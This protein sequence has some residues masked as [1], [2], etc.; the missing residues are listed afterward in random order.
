MLLVQIYEFIPNH[1]NNLGIFL[2]NEVLNTRMY[3]ELAHIITNMQRLYLLCTFFER[4]YVMPYLVVCCFSQIFSQDFTQ[5]RYK[6]LLR[7]A[8][9]LAQFN[10][11]I[12][13]FQLITR[14]NG[15]LFN[16]V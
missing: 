12:I 1:P 9:I 5:Q 10:I 11:Y 13:D 6:I 14:N 16:C 2:K 4:I 7:Y 3:A 8:T 15:Y